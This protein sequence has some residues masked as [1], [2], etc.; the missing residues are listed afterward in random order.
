MQSSI[1]PKLQLAAACFSCYL[2][3]IMSG[4]CLSW[5]EP[6]T[7]WFQSNSTTERLTEEEVSLVVSL[8]EAGAFFSPLPSAFMADKLGRKWSLILTGVVALLGWLLAL[9][10]RNFPSLCASRVLG[11]LALGSVPTVAPVYIAE[12]A[13]ASVRGAL[14]GQLVAMFFLGQVIVYSTGHYLPYNEFLWVCTAVPVV[15]IISFLLLPETPFYLLKVGKEEAAKKAFRRLRGTGDDEEFEQM[16]SSLRSQDQQSVSFRSGLATLFRWDAFKILLLLQLLSFISH[17]NGLPTLSLYA[18]DTF[19]GRTWL[20]VGMGCVLA[21]SSFVAAF[22]TDPIG[23]RPLLIASL[24]GSALFT[25]ILAFYFV[26][27]HDYLLYV[28]VVGFCVISSVGISP[29]IMTLQGELFPTS[30]RAIASGITELTLSF[31]S[32][33]CLYIYLPINNLWGYHINF[34]IYTVLSLIGVIA[35]VLFLPETAK[36]TIDA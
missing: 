33:L 36:V 10:V 5:V 13:P 31:S 4:M 24:A 25:A 15:F 3:L 14:S 1:L 28:G 16:V 27:G 22:L 23:R 7:S 26:E 17:M 20:T 12:I 2:S 11:G 35:V 21:A 19:G 34:I 29:L 32:F 18:T 30:T 9:F 8:V 6:L